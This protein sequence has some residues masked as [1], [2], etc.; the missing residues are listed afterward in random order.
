MTWPGS[1]GPI[2]DSVA[3]LLGGGGRTPTVTKTLLC[4]DDRYAVDTG[5]RCLFC[6]GGGT[7]IVGRW[8]PH[9]HPITNSAIP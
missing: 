3:A 7:L 8:M 2:G 9:S 6:G 4:V 1:V 5:R